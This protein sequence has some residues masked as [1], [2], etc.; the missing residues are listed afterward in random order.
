MSDAS[1]TLRARVLAAASATPSPTRRQGHVA[2]SV[3]VAASVAIAV[4]IF[5]S[6][7]GFGHGSGR[8]F[9]ITMA[10]AAGWALVSSV[11]TWLVV[12]RSGSTM[13]RRPLL[14]AV[15][16]VAVPFVLFLWMQV[17]HGS[18]VQPFHAAG[19]R[20]LRYTLLMSALPLAAF[21]VLRRAIEPRYPSALGAGAGAACASWAGA[22]VDLWCPLTDPMH[23]LVGH[24]APLVLA[25]LVGA[26][27]GHFMLGVRGTRTKP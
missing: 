17:F 23:V 7:G 27:L 9:G 8:P 19:Y 2:A 21:L 3:L 16:A 20:C 4:T 15:A 13:A 25:T 26:A 5:E 18:Y 10:M 12:D 22:L 6:V 24:V 11:L 1:D 14:I